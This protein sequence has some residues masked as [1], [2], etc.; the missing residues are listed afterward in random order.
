MKV[1]RISVLTLGIGLV[2]CATIPLLIQSRADVKPNIQLNASDT[3][4][5]PLEDTTQKAIL[6]DYTAAW[7]AISTALANNNTAPLSDNFTGFALEKLT[8]RVKEQRSTGLTT[9]IIDHGHH[10]N[11][12]FYSRDGSAVELRDTASIETQVLEGST[13]LHSDN[14]QIQYLAVMTGAADRWQVR[15]LENAAGQA[16][17]N[18]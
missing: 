16:A 7:Q 8:Q 17:G 11:A 10:V 14:S 2:I 13:I 18:K 12:I 15:V 5:R 1:L 3:Q 9:R 4:P 6:R